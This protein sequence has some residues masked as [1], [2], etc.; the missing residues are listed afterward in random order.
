MVMEM[1]IVELNEQPVHQLRYL[2]PAR[3]GGTE[4]QVLTFTRARVTDLPGSLDAIVVTSDLQGI[5]PDPYTGE[6]GLL[7]V[8]VA[9]AVE[10]LALDGAV[11]APGRTGVILAGDLYC[12][13]AADKRGGYGDVAPVWAAFASCFAWVAGVAG[14][15]DD[16]TRVRGPN[17]HVLD[18]AIAELSG[19][20]VGGVG[21]VA[22]NP[23][24]RGRRLE[25]EQLDRVEQVAAKSPDVL[26]LHGG[27]SGADDQL[28]HAGIREVVLIHAVPLT[29]CGHRHWARA[30]HRHAR[31][32]VLNVDGRV[33]VLTR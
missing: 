17:V 22:G 11:P 10:E 4:A 9:D 12:V 1:Q 29:I 25:D 16:V 24:L 23:S 21:L 26:V 18:G 30:L 15:H 14:N 20:R 13:P 19:L 3:G 6:A 27:P 2:N 5:V 32:Q 33:V 7:G 8:S 31:G 28:G